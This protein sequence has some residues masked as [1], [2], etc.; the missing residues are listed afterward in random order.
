M[1]RGFAGLLALALAATPLA[2][3]A[4]ASA[5]T[6]ACGITTTDRPAAGVVTAGNAMG[7]GLFLTYTDTDT[8]LEGG[9]VVPPDISSPLAQVSV[10]RTGLGNAL[11]GQFYSPY[12]DAAGVLNAFGGTEL[13]LGGLSEPSRAKVSGRPPQS[14]F[15]STGGGACARLSDGPLAEA[16][17]TAASLNPGITVR[18]GE[19]HATTG[20]KGPGAKSAS[21]V[22]MKD[23]TIG[24]LRIEQI[25]LNALALADGK[26]GATEIQSYITALSVGETR[27]VFDESGFDPEL[28]PAPD[29]SALKAA[30]I[31]FVS[32]GSTQHEAGGA[33]ST[34]VATGPVLRVTSPDG[35][36]LTVVLGQARAVAEYATLG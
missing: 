20:P 10:D 25:V 6:A 17:A 15:L 18:L 32:G 30:G 12:S 29:L 5:A 2:L 7:R 33:V 28:L 24:D 21:T 8:V 16:A 35:R 4:P 1:R 23:V 34:A 27:H 3:A 26:E 19:V 31:E 14:Q 9:T 11:A 36:V 22:V 13:P